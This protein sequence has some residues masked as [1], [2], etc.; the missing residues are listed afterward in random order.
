MI[1]I[2]FPD[3]WTTSKIQMLGHVPFGDE[4]L[5]THLTLKWF[6]TSVGS[7]MDFIVGS[8]VVLLMAA[9]LFTREFEIVLVFF[10]MVF[11]DLKCLEVF[12]AAQICA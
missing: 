7:E 10:K 3:R 5:V 12:R 4:L 9:M 1:S 2:P 11:E 6:D 8:G